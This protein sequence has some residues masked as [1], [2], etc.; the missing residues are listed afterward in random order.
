MINGENSLD[1][2]PVLLV[3]VLERLPEEL[4]PLPAYLVALLLEGFVHAP[5]V[6]LPRVAIPKMARDKTV[7]FQLLFALFPELSGALPSVRRCLQCLVCSFRDFGKRVKRKGDVTITDSHE[8][9][10]ALMG[11]HVAFDVCGRK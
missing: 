1:S 7:R 10:R 3:N 8:Y 4:C 11:S 9:K 5:F 2:T 6:D